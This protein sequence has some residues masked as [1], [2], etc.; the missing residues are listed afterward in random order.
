MQGRENPA[1]PRCQL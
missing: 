1:S